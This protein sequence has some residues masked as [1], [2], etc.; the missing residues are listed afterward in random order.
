MKNKGRILI[1]DDEEVAASNLS[2]VMAK[3]GYT[4]TTALSGIEGLT[5]LQQQS[6]DLLLTDLRMEKIDG[7]ALLQESR[8]LCPDSEVIVITGFATTSNAVEAMKLGAFHYIAK[9]FHF[10]EVR[11][12]VAEA[13]EKVRLRR[14]NK[15][16]R[17]EIASYR[18]KAR[19][20]TQDAATMRLLDLARQVAPTDCNVMVTG[21]SGTGKELIVDYIH[22]HS[23]RGNGPF[24]AVNCGAFN[25]E[26][27]ANELFGHE[28]E[29]FTGAS[30]A[31]KGLIEAAN[32]GTLFLDEITEMPS[33]MQ[34]KL[35]RVIQE[36]EVLRLGATVPA[37]VDIR[38]IAATNRDVL[39]AVADGTFR[40]D[41]YFRL[42]V[43]AIH[44]PPL[45]QRIG[46]V[47]PLVEH[48]QRKFSLQMGKQVTAISTEALDCLQNHTFPG[49]VRELENIIERGVAIASGDTL[50]L[51][52][53]PP[54]LHGNTL[55]TFQKHRGRFM[56]LEE[57]E[58]VYIRWVLE[59]VGGNQ[60]VAAQ[61]LG[62]NRSSLWRKLKQL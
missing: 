7:M 22:H 27:F 60:T 47:P 52:H 44:I 3:E 23:G 62:I 54:H 45:A 33:E 49:N 2:H 20:I 51:E 46:D 57:Q 10:D 59:E 41:L 50:Q 12:V 43:I 55:P 17:Q 28:R 37:K 24:I 15:R 8:N 18:G 25:S 6:F 53:L 16:L 35:L 29:A 1:V 48:F 31:R 32:G 19:F 38:F 4:V 56:T 11:Q 21:E 61:T 42:N 13:L 40:Q 14:E 58:Q 34:V 30:T 5:L 39:Q 36:K 9:P 26:L